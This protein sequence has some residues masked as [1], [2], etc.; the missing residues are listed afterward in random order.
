[1]FLMGV[2][3]AITVAALASI[4]VGAKE[5]A[6]KLGGKENALMAGIVW[7]V[8]LLGA[9]AVLGFGVVLLLASL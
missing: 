3:T 8:E 9:V 7:W 4:A 5:L 6:R 1:V 2:G